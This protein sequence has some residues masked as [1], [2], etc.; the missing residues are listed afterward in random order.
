MIFK[1]LVGQELKQG[2]QVLF[3]I[4]LGQT[5]VATVLG[6]NSGL[7][8]NNPQAAV[9]VGVTFILPAAP[10]GLVNGLVRVAAAPAA[11]TI[12]EG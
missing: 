3:S 5:T 9:Q 6:T 11:P 1:D 10:N 8:P 7:D 12:S 2:D 4:G